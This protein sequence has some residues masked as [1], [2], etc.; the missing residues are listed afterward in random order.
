MLFRFLKY[1]QPTHYFLLST[2]KGWYQFPEVSQLPEE[3]REQLVIDERYQS[4]KAREYDMSWQ[5]LTLGYTGNTRQL[6]SFEQLPLKDNYRFVA[7]YFAKPWYFYVFLL[8]IL[9][10]CNPISEFLAF[11]TMFKVSRVKGQEPISE[12][13]ANRGQTVPLEK[14]LISII[15]PT[16]NRYP[17]L[18][19]GLHDLEKQDYQNSE[20]L[21]VDQSDNF[22]PSFYKQFNLEIQVIRQEEK[23]LWLARNTAIQKAKGDYILLFDDDSRVEPDWVSEHLRALW[24]YGAD[25]SSGVSLSTV[26]AA[27][28]KN[29]SFFIISDQFDTGN[30]MIKRKV[31]QQIGLF[32]RQFEKQR[33]GDG[34]FGLR[35][36]LH[37]FRNI[38]N[39]KAKRVHLKVGSGGLRDMGSWDAFRTKGLLAPRPI[40]SV[41]YFYRRYF[42]NTHARYALAKGIPPSIIP[43]SMKSN[44]I[45]TLLG[46]LGGV[47]I[48]PL[49]LIQIGRSW[50]MASKK[51]KQGPLIQQLD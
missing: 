24:E 9:S 40:P 43:Y 34:E 42:G 14:P 12:N 37:G 32:D 48:L 3:I 1:L 26:G 50:S 5:A 49:I 23:A 10:L 31:F 16:L 22:A 35:A 51:L 46:I 45:M 33:M 6:R 18:K 41:L 17:Y 15:I 7:K 36:Y 29:Y 19:E 38:S 47:L 44:K 21:I 13:M 39:P 25:I 20:I 28:P 27:V 8:R 30:V 2:K 4:E 11:I